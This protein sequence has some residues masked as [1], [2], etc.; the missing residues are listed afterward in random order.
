LKT[1]TRTAPAILIVLFTLILV[2][3]FAGNGFAQKYLPSADFV[4]AAAV[5]EPVSLEWKISQPLALTATTV[6]VLPT[7]SS[8]QERDIA[9]W[10][11]QGLYNLYGINPE[12]MVTDLIPEQ[13]AIVIGVAKSCPTLKDLVPSLST[14]KFGRFPEQSYVLSVSQRRALLVGGGILGLKYGA[15]TLLQVVCMDSYTSNVVLPPVEI[16]DFPAFDMRA[17][18]LPLRGYRFLEQVWDARELID[19]AEMLHMNT[20]IIQV[21]NAIKFDSVRGVARSGALEKDTLRAIVKYAREAGLEVIPFV[22]TFSHQDVLLCPAYPDLCLDNSTYDPSNPKVYAKLFGIIDEILEIFEPKYM[23]VGHD[24]IRALSNIPQKKA[25]EL[26]L[27]DIRKIHAHLKQKKVQ[28]M[29]W[30]SMLLSAMQFQGQDNCNGV[31]GNTYALIDSLPKDIIIV[32]AHY[33]QRKPDF[34]TVDYLL[35]KGFPV[36]GCVFNEPQVANNFSKYAAGKEGNFLGM[37]V[38]LW[39]CFDYDGMSTPRGITRE[40]AEAFW[41]GGI[42]PE[43]PMG[44]QIPT[45]LRGSRNPRY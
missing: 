11:K 18:L 7:S 16:A 25:A 33:S 31:L 35:S 28:M 4:R 39:G 1:G 9:A 22:N 15:Q 5:P 3:M 34:P 19:V 29:M 12:I 38:A 43:D 36:V 45:N 42:P 20:V 10:V 14:E 27:S 40:G 30:A 21:D 41:R 17:L 24:E 6:I 37:A 13:N 2:A 32:D 8:L 26:F 23:H 44:Q